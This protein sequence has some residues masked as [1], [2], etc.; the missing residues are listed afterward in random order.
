MAPRFILFLLGSGVLLGNIHCT[1]P[2]LRG[3]QLDLQRSTLPE[4]PAE[5]VK[6]A[7]QTWNEDRDLKSIARGAAALEKALNTSTFPVNWRLFDTTLPSR[8]C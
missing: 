1:V 5:L 2:E 4:L 8:R 6:L 3:D 7:D